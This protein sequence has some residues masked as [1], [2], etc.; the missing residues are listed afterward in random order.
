MDSR[1][2]WTSRRRAQLNRR[3][4]LGYAG[5]ASAGWVLAACGSGDS[6]QDT[7]QAAATAQGGAAPAG[8]QQATSTSEWDKIVAA[9]KKEG[10]LVW[11]AYAGSPGQDDVIAKF[12]DRTGIK[13]QLLTGRTGDFRARWDAER[14]AG[15]PTIDIRSS[16]SP[17]NRGL[18][19]EKLDQPFGELP[20]LA[21]GVQW[22]SDPLVDVKAGNGHTLHYTLTN[23]Y[24]LVNN[25]LVPESMGFKSYKDLADPKFKGMI[26][27][28]E[29][30]GPSPGS[31][32]AAYT[33]AEYGDPYLKA[34]I[35]NVKALSRQTTEAPKQIA[36]GEYG[37]Y[38]HLTQG[39]L[40]DIWELPKP[41]PFRIIVPEDGQMVLTGGISFLQGAPHPNAAKVFL[42]YILT[43]EAQ[44][45]LANHAGGAFI[46][47]DVTPKVP[48]VVK[49]GG[50]FFPRNPDTYE[51]GSKH[52]FEWSAKAEPFLKESGLK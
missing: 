51:F 46:R 11:S 5:I 28:D 2:G 37:I 14:A 31:R 32:W 13:I 21:A 41:H 7:G 47:P 22:L 19:A 52:F 33:Y 8:Q 3:R 34:V 50:K 30:I 9:A 29:P 45:L 16:G 39:T 26:L 4:L 20:E 48:E 12:E 24:L 40:A 15:K 27:L 23:Y 1:N 18:S 36:R 6:A 17:E 38:I 25:R 35:Q 42:N 10:T 43:K 49:F 44:Q